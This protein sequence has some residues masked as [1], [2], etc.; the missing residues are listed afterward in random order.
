MTTKDNVISTQT[1]NTTSEFPDVIV[2]LH[3]RLLRP[4]QYR[5]LS[6]CGKISGNSEVD[7]KP[8]A[9]ENTGQGLTT[10]FTQ[11]PI[12]KSD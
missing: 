9:T 12:Q 4:F 10:T 8:L 6:F 2:L 5:F 7:L 11:H 1:K 3:N